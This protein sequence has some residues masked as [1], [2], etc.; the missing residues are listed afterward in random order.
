MSH[1]TK[2]LNQTE[3]NNLIT[4]SMFDSIIFSFIWLSIIYL[5][6]FIHKSKIITP[7][8]IFIFLSKFFY[9]INEFIKNL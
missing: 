4:H 6:V 1:N 8:I 3:I 7:V 2:L 5:S 9:E